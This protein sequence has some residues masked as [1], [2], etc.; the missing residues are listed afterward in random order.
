MNKTLAMVLCLGLF[1]CSDQASTEWQKKYDTL[2]AEYQQLKTEHEAL[3]AKVEPKTAA[4]G[5]DLMVE[6]EA[7]KRARYSAVAAALKAQ[8]EAIPLKAELGGTMFFTDIKTLNDEWVYGAYE[9]GHVAGSALFAYRVDD[10][11]KVAFKVVNEL[12]E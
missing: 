6:I 12:T 3:V 5:D 11:Q 10:G 7:E 2:N 8:P 4:S 1:A 9:D